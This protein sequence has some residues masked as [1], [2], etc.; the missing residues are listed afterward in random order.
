MASLLLYDR[1]RRLDN[2]LVSDETSLGA[3]DTGN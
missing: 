1:A 2:Y 3:I